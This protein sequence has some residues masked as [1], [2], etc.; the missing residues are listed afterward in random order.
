[1][2]QIN[3]FPLQLG[4][5]SSIASTLTTHS[6]RLHHEHSSIYPY[7]SALSNIDLPLQKSRDWY[8]WCTPTPHRYFPPPPS[9]TVSNTL[10]PFI[11]SLPT[12]DLNQ[13]NKKVINLLISNLF[14]K[15][16]FIRLEEGTWL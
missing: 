16:T 6:H 7:L 15:E 3:P 4:H 11:S 13:Q 2:F 12:F 9:L 1:M 10:A 8:H 14:N 5:V